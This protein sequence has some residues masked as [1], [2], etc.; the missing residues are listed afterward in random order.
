VSHADRCIDSEIISYLTGS[1]GDPL[2]SSKVP[3]NRNANGQLIQE[4]LK[5]IH[6]SPKFENGKYGKSGNIK[7]TLKCF[8]YIF[9]GD[10][11]EMMKW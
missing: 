8:D 11:L 3:W 7:D 4:A 9:Q 5:K 1:C 6:I 10:N 2:A